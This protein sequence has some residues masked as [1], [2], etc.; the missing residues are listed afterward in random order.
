MEGFIAV[1]TRNAEIAQLGKSSLRN[2]QNQ[3]TNHKSPS[4]NNDRSYRFLG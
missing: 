4:F 3:Q 1:E 2:S